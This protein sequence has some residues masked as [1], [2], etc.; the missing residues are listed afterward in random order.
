V[1]EATDPDDHTRCTTIAA[2]IDIVTVP[3][4]LAF[5][6]KDFRFEIDEIIPL[7]MGNAIN[8]LEWR[9]GS[10]RCQAQCMWAWRKL[11]EDPTFQ[12]RNVRV[13][14]E[15]NPCD[16]SGLASRWASLMGRCTGPG[17]GW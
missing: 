9:F 7:V 6:S 15:A 12:S 10:Y 4:L 14:F 5:F 3:N 1:A 17:T 8:V 11:R 2:P 16:W 13:K